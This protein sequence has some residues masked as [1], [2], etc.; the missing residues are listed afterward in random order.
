VRENH[1]NKILVYYGDYSIDKVYD[2][3]EFLMNNE[4]N[5]FRIQQKI[6]K[7]GDKFIIKDRYIA[8]TDIYFLLFDP[9]ADSR[10]YGRLLFWG[11]IRQIA[12]GKGSEISSDY[13]YLEWRNEVDEVVVNFE[14]MFFKSS[15]QE[16]MQRATIKINQL[17]EKFKIF[18]DDINKPNVDDDISLDKLKLLI[19]FKEDLLSKQHSQNLVKELMNMYQKAIEIL[20]A[21]N[22]DS[23]K[24]YLDKLHNMLNEKSKTL[25]LD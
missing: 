10:N 15:V 2:M 20:S 8:L 3:N 21:N 25:K 4:I 22:D 24:L 9:L 19:K 12:S 17:K 11:D 5:F 7:G 13:L 14:I 1:S 18:Q 23:F 6:R 16:F